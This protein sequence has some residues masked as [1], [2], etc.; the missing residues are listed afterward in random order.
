MLLMHSLLI[1]PSTSYSLL[2]ALPKY[3]IILSIQTR[4]ISSYSS[5]FVFVALSFTISFER[6]DVLSSVLT[7]ALK[8][9]QYFF[10]F[11]DVDWWCF[12]K[13]LFKMPVSTARRPWHSLQSSILS[14]NLQCVNSL[15]IS[16]SWVSAPSEV[17]RLGD[18]AS[19]AIARNFYLSSLACLS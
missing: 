13:Q 12:R 9:L 3:M 2:Y 7:R 17:H 8:T 5:I 14:F 19:G 6:N 4:L 11:V 16:W 10:N 15:R 1:T 18:P